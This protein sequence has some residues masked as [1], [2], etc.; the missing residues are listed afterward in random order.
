MVLNAGPDGHYVLIYTWQY[1]VEANLSNTSFYSTM[2]SLGATVDP[3]YDQVP[4]L[5]LI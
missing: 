4:Y 5:V 1:L 2:A 3:S